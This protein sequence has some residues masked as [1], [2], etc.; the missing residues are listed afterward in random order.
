M[1]VQEE[2]INAKI[3]KIQTN[4]SCCGKKSKMTKIKPLQV[5]YF[6]IS[7]VYLLEFMLLCSIFLIIGFSFLVIQGIH[8]RNAVQKFNKAG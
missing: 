1:E 5:Y 6:V 3:M 4:I 7:E 8:E 2:I